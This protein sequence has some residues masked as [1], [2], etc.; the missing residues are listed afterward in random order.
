[1]LSLRFKEQDLVQRKIEFLI[2]FKKGDL[3][4]LGGLFQDIA[5]YF[6]NGVVHAAAADQ[7]LILIQIVDYLNAYLH[8]TTPSADSI[9]GLRQDEKGET[10]SGRICARNR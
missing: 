4:V 2:L 9:A 1:M 10:P 5:V 8:L 6:L 3:G 7:H